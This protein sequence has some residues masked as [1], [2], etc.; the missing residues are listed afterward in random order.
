MKSLAQ[1]RAANALTAS[2]YPGIGS[3][4][5]EGNVLSGFPQIVWNNGLLAAAASALELGKNNHLRNRG[6]FAV[7]FAIAGHLSTEG[8]AIYQPN[9]PLPAVPTDG[10]DWDTCRSSMLSFVEFL[11]NGEGAL[12]R[13]AT[14]ETIAYLAYLKRFVA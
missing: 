14:A 6:E 8:V 3:G 13:R 10:R 5:K 9:S 12:L 4:Q 2:H 11:A 7:V 1:L